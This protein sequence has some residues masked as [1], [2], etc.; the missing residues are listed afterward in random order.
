L[1]DSDGC[2][3]WVDAIIFKIGIG[4]GKA[5]KLFKLVQNNKIVP[6]NYVI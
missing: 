5:K 6:V 3:F 4:L 2:V 1:N